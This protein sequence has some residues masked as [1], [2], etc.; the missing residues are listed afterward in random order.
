[1]IMVQQFH[2]MV[3]V[4]HAT[5][6]YWILLD[7]SGKAKSRNDSECLIAYLEKYQHYFNLGRA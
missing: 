4:M 3:I 5:G 2:H 7:I 6:Y 1:M